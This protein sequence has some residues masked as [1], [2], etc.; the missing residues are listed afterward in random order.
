MFLLSKKGLTTKALFV[1]ETMP[2]INAD[3]TM[4]ESRSNFRLSIISDAFWAVINFIGLFFDTLINP[5]KERPKKTAYAE[6]VA[7]RKATGTATYRGP[8]RSNIKT[9][10]KPSCGPKG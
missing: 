3:G 2:Y 5:S 1:Y 6:E 4:V 7:R 9:M 8:K 10:P